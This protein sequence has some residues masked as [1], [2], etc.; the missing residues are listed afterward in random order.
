MRKKDKKYNYRLQP[1][2]L[3]I[4]KEN[5]YC[6]RLRDIWTTVNLASKWEMRPRFRSLVASVKGSLGLDKHLI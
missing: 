3:Q 4:D 5:N 1:K 2:K 6:S